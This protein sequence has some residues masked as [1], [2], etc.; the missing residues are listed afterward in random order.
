MVNVHKQNQAVYGREGKKKGR[1]EGKK[2]G[3]KDGRT[4]AWKQGRK[5]E[6]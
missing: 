6:N 2:K 4:E 3:Q 1:D 5:E